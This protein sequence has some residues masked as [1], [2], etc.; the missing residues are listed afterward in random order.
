M[1]YLND[2]SSKLVW[3]LPLL[4]FSLFFAYFLVYKI[5]SDYFKPLKIQDAPYNA[6]LFANDMFWTITNVTAAIIMGVSFQ[7]LWS[8]GYI[9]FNTSSPS[10]FELIYEFLILFVLYD[11]TYYFLHRG[12]HQEP[13]YSWIHIHHH[14]SF[15]PTFFTAFA[16]HPIEGMLAALIAVFWVWALNF[17]YHSIFILLGIFGGAMNF[18]VHC[19]HEYFPRNWLKKWYTKWFITPTFH[20]IHHSRVNCNFSAFTIIPDYLMGTLSKDLKKVFE[21]IK[22]RKAEQ[23][24]FELDIKQSQT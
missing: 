12:L 1:A 22:D 16:F 11:A 13:F 10:I 2:I 21:K 15:S 9:D 4:I 5:Y 3:I 8:N 24:T 17:H 7:Y 23:E 20:D 19:A 18:S 14:K 6:K